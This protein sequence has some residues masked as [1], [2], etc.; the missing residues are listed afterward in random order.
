MNHDSSY[1]DLSPEQAAAYAEEVEKKY[2]PELV[3]QSR[4]RLAGWTKEDFR[5]AQEESDQICRALAKSMD[6]GAE[7]EAVQELIARHFRHINC[8]YDCT[9]EIYN[10]LSDL[11]V[12]DPRFRAHF[13]K[14]HES[15]PEFLSAAMKAYVDRQKT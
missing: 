1:G 14:F 10:G 13:A 8:Y 3:R 4:E 2:D 6:K 9:L 5:R 7:D 11:Y 12:Q 15:L